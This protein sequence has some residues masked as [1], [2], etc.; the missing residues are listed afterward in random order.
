VRTRRSVVPPVENDMALATRNGIVTAS[1][2]LACYAVIVATWYAMN[3]TSF[4][5]FVTESGEETTSYG[6]AFAPLNWIAETLKERRASWLECGP[7]YPA[8]A[9]LQAAT[10][11]LVTYWTA[12]F[13]FLIVDVYFEARGLL[14]RYKNAH[15]GFTPR[16]D[17]R[18]YRKACYYMVFISAFTA[19]LHATVYNPLG[20]W[21]GACSYD[22]TVLPDTLVGWALVVGKLFAMYIITD[23]IF[24]TTHRLCHEVPVLYKNVH[25]WHHQWVV[26][27]GI[28]ASA[29]HPI[30]QWF[31]NMNTVELPGLI[32]GLP[33]PL[34]VLWNIFAGFNTVANHSGYNLFRTDTHDKH[35]HF[36]NCEFGTD[37]FC[38]RLFGTTYEDRNR[39]QRSK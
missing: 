10:L 14:G 26:T 4:T 36:N 29:A 21:M 12:A 13:V 38:D 27:Y 6:S 24:Y 37:T 15:K 5:T 19:T 11:P 32:V 25:K 39:Q 17:H 20:Q 1:A 30:E 34:Q 2:F 23:V 8:W 35:H 3:F 16:L 22:K 9:G 28:D 33:Y 18:L 7:L 31:V